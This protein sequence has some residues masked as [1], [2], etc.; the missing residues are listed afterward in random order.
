MQT[1]MMEKTNCNLLW[2]GSVTTPLVYP[3]KSKKECW[4]LI[5]VETIPPRDPQVTPQMPDVEQGGRE[6]CETPNGFHS[7]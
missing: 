7:L 3:S 4:A 6:C 2:I 5:K 1:V